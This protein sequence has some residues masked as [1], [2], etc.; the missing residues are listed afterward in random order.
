[1]TSHCSSAR[2]RSPS[3]DRLFQVGRAFQLGLT[4]ERAHE[5]TRIDPWFLHHIREI[6]LAEMD[7]AESM[8]PR[9]AA[10]SSGSA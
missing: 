6:A 7:V 2:S 3:P 10:R 4:A 1:M 8:G 5:L 9:D